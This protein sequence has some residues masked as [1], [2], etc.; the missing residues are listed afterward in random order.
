MAELIILDDQHKES[1]KEMYELHKKIRQIFGTHHQIGPK[2]DKA[3]D[4]IDD[5]ITCGM[6]PDIFALIASTQT[7]ATYAEMFSDD[8]DEYTKEY[9]RIHAI[10]MNHLGEYYPH[11]MQFREANIARYE[12]YFKMFTKQ[13]PPSISE[14]LALIVQDQNA[15]QAAAIKQ[16]QAPLEPVENATTTTNSNPAEAIDW[17]NLDIAEI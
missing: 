7:C 6:I 10:I 9:K 2:L 8:Q 16:A 3:H 1:Y 14:V 13:N 4:L 12:K 11:F 17:D 15:L 5:A